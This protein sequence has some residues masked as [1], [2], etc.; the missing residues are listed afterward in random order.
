MKIDLKFPYMNAKFKDQN[1]CDF[2]RGKQKGIGGYMGIF[3]IRTKRNL[4]NLICLKENS[5]GLY[6][7]RLNIKNEL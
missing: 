6:G 7:F 2:T 3:D 4:M 5:A 1:F